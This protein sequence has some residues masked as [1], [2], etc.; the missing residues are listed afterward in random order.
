M[1]HFTDKKGWNAIRATPTWRFKAFQPPQKAH[2]VG[3]YF[4]T[5]GPK[6]LNLFTKIRVPKM[7]QEYLFSFVD[8]GDLKSLDSDRGEWIFYSPHDYDVVRGRQT[9]E[10]RSDKA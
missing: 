5:L 2:P 4:T 1:N 3:A 7:K 8:A 9:Y 6:E 10:G